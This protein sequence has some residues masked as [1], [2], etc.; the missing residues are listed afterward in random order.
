MSTDSTNRGKKF[1]KDFG[2]YSIGIFGT[3]IIT[4]L[5]V[6][7]YTYFLDDTA[8]Y[9]Y[10]D[11]C[12]QICMFLLPL[13]TLQLRDASFRFLIET[14]ADE[15]RRRIVSFVYKALFSNIVVI[16]AVAILMSMLVQVNYLYHS[17]ALLVAMTLHEVVGQVTRGLKH[18][19]IYVACNLLN[20]FLIGSLSFLFIVVFR[21]G[22][23]GIFLANILSRL[24]AV[25]VLELKVKI[26]RRYFFRSIDVRAI[27]K[28][29]M[30][31]SLPLIPTNMCWLLT[32]IS[33]RFF[34]GYFV[35]V[36]VNGIY[37]VTIRF[38]M[39]LQTLA[40]IFYQAWQETAITQYHTPDRNKFFSKV[41]N[42]YLFAWVFLLVIFS[43]VLKMNYGWLVAPNYQ[44][45]IK[46]LY[47]M[48]IITILMSISSSYFE[49]GYQCGKDTKRAIP[50]LFFAAIVNVT[51]NFLITP[52]LGVKGVIL[53]NF[54]TF[55][56]LCVYR[57]IDTR[58]YF[59]ISI[60]GRT[61]ALPAI[62]VA[63]YFLFALDEG[64]MVDVLSMLVLLVAVLAVMP[65][66]LTGQIFQKVKQ[67]LGK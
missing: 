50:A 44:P 61:F 35:S 36:E 18:N 19:E 29:I 46:Y 27:G 32:T 33:D 64:V 20:A 55:V 14:D 65:R 57:F 48:G 23:E 1:A 40:L 42:Y 67:K 4:F 34:I 39:I 60:Y 17:L 63:G 2:I 58:R 54:C 53:S 51:V 43:F 16:A 12:L 21:M 9:G 49:L 3:R 66:E 13:S 11:M 7:L 45:G 26:L 5:M 31:Y 28:E 38:T 37:A 24:T 22:V 30:R 52:S 6:P 8:E 56:F 10:Y 47:A 41:F 15:S 25:T 62:L 59:K